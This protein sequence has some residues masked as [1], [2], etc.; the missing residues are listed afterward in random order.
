MTTKQNFLTN[1]TTTKLTMCVLVAVTMSACSTQP[2]QTKNQDIDKNVE[3]LTRQAD[4]DCQDHAQSMANHAELIA[5]SAQYLAAAKAMNSCVS[6]ALQNRAYN[7]SD[8]HDV[9]IMK[10]MATATLNFIKSGDVITA[11]REVER[12]KRTYPNQDLYFK[13]YTSFLDT[14]MALL[15]LEPL[16]S[17]QLSA[18]NISRE[19]R[20]EIERK[21]Y[22]LNH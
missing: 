15:S 2:P 19:L 1:M 3:I 18:L 11:S 9:V 17:S 4:A 10:M 21:H 6:S 5:S 20:D 16:H 12:F 7:H 8:E 14:A 22:W 13:D